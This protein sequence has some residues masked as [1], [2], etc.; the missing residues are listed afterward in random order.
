MLYGEFSV[1]LRS[2]IVGESDA[3]PVVFNDAEAMSPIVEAVLWL[4]RKWQLLYIDLRPPNVRVC[5]DGSLR[6]VDY[7][8][9]VVLTTSPC[10]DHKTVS[11]LRENDHVLVIFDHYDQLAKLF[12]AAA[13][14][15]LRCCAACASNGR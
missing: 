10:C 2:S 12:D 6:L 4:A 13:A 5:R 1:C 9:L 3:C 11:I 14:K 8:D 7:D 15:P